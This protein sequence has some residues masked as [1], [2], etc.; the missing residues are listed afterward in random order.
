MQKKRNL[1]TCGDVALSGHRRGLLFVN[2]QAA[3]LGKET[4]R[5][6]EQ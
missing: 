6:T 2:E 1:V 3:K 4:A 5:I